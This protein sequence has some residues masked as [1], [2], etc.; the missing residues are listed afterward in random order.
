MIKIGIRI[1]ARSS[2]VVLR[3]HLPTF[4]RAA[5]LDPPLWF[6]ILEL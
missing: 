1:S 6:D 2:N 5:K 3:A 4:N